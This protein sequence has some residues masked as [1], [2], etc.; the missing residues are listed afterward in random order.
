M[1]VPGS[2]AKPSSRLGRRPRTH[3]AITHGTVGA[4]VRRGGDALAGRRRVRR[5][6]PAGRPNAARSSGETVGGGGGV[7]RRARARLERVVHARRAAVDARPRHRTRPDR[8]SRACAVAAP[9]LARHAG[10]PRPP[11]RL[12]VRVC[13]SDGA[14]CRPQAARSEPDQL[15][16]SP[17]DARAGR[18]R[19]VAPAA[20]GGTG[21]RRRRT[22]GARPLTASAPSR[23]PPAPPRRASG[24]VARGAVG[25]G[26]DGHR[27]RQRARPNAANIGVPSSSTYGRRRA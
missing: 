20:S 26:C 19:A 11:R 16:S 10:P 14:A 2:G 27:A 4:G 17:T 18:P 15:G 24:T 7:R 12:S 25:R 13:L 22:V 23:P 9:V 21:R 8:S 6:R 5:R 1:R 3:S